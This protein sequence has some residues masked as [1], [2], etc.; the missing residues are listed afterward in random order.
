MGVTFINTD[1][2]S[3]YNRVGSIDTRVGL[4]SNWFG[5]LQLARSSTRTA[6]GRRLNGQD[7]LAEIT[8]ST[9]HTDFSSTWTDRS[10]GFRAE[11]GYIPRVD[12][13]EWKNNATYRWRPKN[14]AVVAF[15]PGMSQGVNWDRKGR[16]QEWWVNPSFTV[17]MMPLTTFTIEHKQSY[18]LFQN[19]GFRQHTSK[20]HVSSD[21]TKRLAF[22][23]NYQFGSGINYYPR[24]G[25]PPFAVHTTNVD[26]GFTLRPTARMKLD[27]SYI[28]TRLGADKA[29][30]PGNASA[31]TSTILVNHILRT[32]ANYQ[33]TRALA[34]RTIV[35][36]N[37]VLPNTSLISL[38]KNKRIGVDVLL[39]YLLH[40][41]TAF[42]VGYSDAYENVSFDPLQNPAFR[43]TQFPGTNTGR[44]VFA[45]LSYLLRY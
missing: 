21:L 15:G 23:G 35:D 12:I 16:V 22:N 14:S 41:G 9:A 24:A 32:K 38:E 6:D 27:E 5:K 37:G 1:F 8:N 36:Y 40:P 26:G 33:F 44:Q 18:E 39:S 11:L 25:L 43:R 30:L 17:E 10:P 31:G 7:V 29:W 19:L 20:L 13:R 4:G 34:L 42:Y 45:K 2:G 28:Y 3:T